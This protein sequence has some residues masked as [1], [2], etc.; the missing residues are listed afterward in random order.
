MSSTTT[1]V[2]TWR[3]PIIEGLVQCSI[4]NSD[5]GDWFAVTIRR[6]S[7]FTGTPY[8]TQSIMLKTSIWHTPRTTEQATRI[9]HWLLTEVPLSQSDVNLLGAF[10]VQRE[11]PRDI[12]F[13]GMGMGMI[14]GLTIGDPSIKKKKRAQLAVI[15]DEGTY[16]ELT[17]PALAQLTLSTALDTVT[18]EL[19]RVGGVTKKL[20]PDTADWLMSEPA[21]ALYVADRSTLN[22]IATSA[23]TAAVLTSR[24][25]DTTPALGISP[26]VSAEFLESF[27]LT[28][29][30]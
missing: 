15:I 3:T 18:R 1:H 27:T 21:T 14:P 4:T 29:A 16:A 7:W 22:A 19:R 10:A 28:K 26:A 9:A 12:I 2:R 17:K 5:W 11:V 24:L 23:H 30:A 20:H 25:S 8:A 6:Q 13:F